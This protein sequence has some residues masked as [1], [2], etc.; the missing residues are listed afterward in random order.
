MSYIIL[1]I[2]NCISDDAW[3]LPKIDWINTDLSKRYHD[4]HMLSSF[5]GA[6]NTHLGDGHDIIISTS[7]PQFYEQITRHWLFLKGILPVALFMRKDNDYRTT[8]VLKFEHSTAIVALMTES[9]FC[10]YDDSSEVVA[11]YE[12][13]GIYVKQIFIND[14]KQYERYGHAQDSSRNSG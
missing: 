2:D 12:E 14:P 1:D 10:V 8:R 3:R 7:R 13:L 6:C 11:M 9:P 5:D 4:Y